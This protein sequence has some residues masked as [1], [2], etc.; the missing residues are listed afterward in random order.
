M[1]NKLGR[2]LVYLKA[3]Q[4]HVLVLHRQTNSETN[5]YA[6]AAYA[7]HT[8]TKSHTEA[9]LYAGETFM[10]VSLKKQKCMSKSQA[11]AEFIALTDNLRFAE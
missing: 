8:D 6:D 10:F 7:L 1:C 2:V 11:E 3:T 9:V 5:M 4:E